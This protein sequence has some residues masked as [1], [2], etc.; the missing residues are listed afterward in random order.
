[1]LDNK[2]NKFKNSWL[3]YDLPFDEIEKNPEVFALRQNGFEKRTKFQEHHTTAVFFEKVDLDILTKIISETE[4]KDQ[5]NFCKEVFKITGTGILKH[6]TGK[7]AYFSIQ[8]TEENKALV[9]K[10][11]LKKNN[12]YNSKNSENLHISI[13]GPD[14]FCVKKPKQKDLEEPFYIKGALVFVG[15]DG[16][17]FRKFSW[18]S[19][20]KIFEE[21]QVKKANRDTKKINNI[22]LPNKPHLDPIAAYY[23]L[24]RFGSEEF[25]GIKDAKVSFWESSHDPSQETMNQWEKEGSVLIDFGGGIFDH[26]MDNSFSSLLVAK[27]LGIEN[28]PELKAILEYLREDDNFGLHN[29]FGDLAHIIKMM[30]KQN[31]DIQ[32]IFDFAFSALNTM[33][34]FDD[35]SKKEFEEKGKIHKI[36][37][38]K[39]KIKVAI[40]ESDNQN[41]SRYAL[42]NER[43]GVVV[44]KRSSG[45]IM[46]FTNNIYN[47]DLRDIVGAIRKKELEI[48]GKTNIDIKT[49]K[50]EGKHPEIQHW[51]YHKSLNALLNGSDAL[52]DTPP[53]KMP[54]DEIIKIVLFSISTEFPDFCKNKECVFEKCPNFEHSFYK[55]YKKRNSVS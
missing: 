7:Y 31:I 14:P 44:Q 27:F 13:G 25:P 33:I 15:Y 41:I 42:Q 52:A 20:L 35:K 18:N 17:N 34:Y 39:S 22:I 6:N 40:I 50:R 48:L 46:I 3:G 55:C 24:I 51:Y 4:K 23:L 49:L 19:R 16:K 47:I 30:Y 37:R 28:N 1:M 45:H 2:N 26:H 32:K 11:I 21:I 12:L 9:L 38:G 43:I 5:C 29:K 10:N 36:K 53:T 8:E 54:L